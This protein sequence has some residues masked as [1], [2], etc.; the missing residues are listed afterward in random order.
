MFSKIK[1]YLSPILYYNYFIIRKKF[2]FK[3]MYFFSKNPS[4]IKY[5]FLWFK[6]KNKVGYSIKYQLPWMPFNAIQWLKKQLFLSTNVFEWSSGGSTLFF[7]NKV[8]SLISVEHDK[9]WYEVML[10][11]LKSKNII[12][13]SYNFEKNPYLYAQFINKYPDEF[14][15][16]IVV[17]GI[18]RV[19]CI[20]NAIP[21][22]KKGGYIVL[23]N[24]E[25]P[26]Y[27]NGVKKLN[28][29]ER[30]DFWGPGL[31]NKYFWKTTIFKK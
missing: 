5:L 22:I 17:D 10:T 28:K 13:C 8:K 14:F 6:S 2:Y 25:R 16:I 23:D 7:A 21:K 30:K 12:N 20:K 1:K 29:F 4:L 26:E 3:L 9:I 19:S 24:S 31:Q 27:D 18:E 11:K 15:D